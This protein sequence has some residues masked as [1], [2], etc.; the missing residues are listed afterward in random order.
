M[1]SEGWIEREMKY[2]RDV[3]DPEALKRAS[4]ILKDE[5]VLYSLK[6][7]SEYIDTFNV[8]TGNNYEWLREIVKYSIGK[9]EMC[10]ATLFTRL[11][12][13]KAQAL[14]LDGLCKGFYAK[15]GEREYMGVEAI[16]RLERLYVRF[17]VVVVKARGV[18]IEWGEEHRI[19]IE[20]IDRQ[21]KMLIDTANT[22]YS[23]MLVGRGREVLGRIL[24][25]LEAY[26]KSHFKF[27]E[28]IM[29]RYDYPFYDRHKGEHEEFSSMIS[30]LN[31]EFR[32]GRLR[33]AKDVLEVLKEWIGKHVEEE[34]RKLALFLERRGIRIGAQD[35]LNR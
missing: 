10:Y 13:I 31:G 34:D 8:L 14:L 22:L 35:K 29:E 12:D 3:V 9:K 23:E 1:S 20:E 6:L 26:A 15:I 30:R 17:T 28:R 21:H 16:V 25:T 4:S 11:A 19:G 24:N 2:F 18:Y 27:E 5:D 7:G 33:A 32:A